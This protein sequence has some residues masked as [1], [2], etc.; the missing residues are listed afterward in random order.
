MNRVRG[1]LLWTLALSVGAVQRVF[2][3]PPD[4]EEPR[5]EARPPLRFR[6]L[7][8]E[9]RFPTPPPILLTEGPAG[10][11]AMPR[12]LALIDQGRWGRLGLAG[13]A[14]SAAPEC[15]TAGAACVPESTAALLLDFGLRAQPM[16]IFFGPTVS[17]LALTRPASATTHGPDTA[18][19]GGF[20]FG[21]RF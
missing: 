8:P 3:A 4:D 15:A 5:L 20:M 13:L 7:D 18:V 1:L 19:T 2:A 10:S 14:R 9:L 17:T 6:I 11:R 12:F 21:V 16:T